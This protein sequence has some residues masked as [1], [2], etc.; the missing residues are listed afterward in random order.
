MTAHTSN[1]RFSSVLAASALASAG[2]HALVFFGLSRVD[3]SPVQPTRTAESRL[4]AL[5]WSEPALVPPIDPVPEPVPAPEPEPEPEPEPQPQPAPEPPPPPEGRLGIAESEQDT[6]NWLGVADP[7]EHRAMQFETE[8]PSWS[9][10]PGIPLPPGN[11][12]T[13]GAPTPAMPAA[14]EPAQ[15]A[16]KGDPRSEPSTQSPTAS[17]REEGPEDAKLDKEAREQTTGPSE[18]PMPLPAAA[19]STRGVPDAADN[20]HASDII[21]PTRLAPSQASEGAAEPAPD[22]SSEPSLDVAN[23]AKPE[24]ADDSDTPIAE[25]A[26]EASKGDADATIEGEGVIKTGEPLE[27]AEPVKLSSQEMAPL[28]EQAAL[29]APLPFTPPMAMKVSDAMREALRVATRQGVTDARTESDEAVAARASQA[30]QEPLASGGQA[31]APVP[32][33][34]RPAEISEADSSPT[35]RIPAI[36]VKLGRPAAGQGLEVITVRPRF[37]VTTTLT[38]DPQRS[39]IDVVFGRDGTVLK[40]AFVEGKTTGY[41]EVDGPLLDAVYRWRAKGKALLD[42][43]PGRDPSKGLLVTFHIE[44]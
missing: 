41:K 23:A 27:D 36:D 37:S 3:A 19:E 35:S 14:D 29:L 1:P 4:D 20:P 22:A 15:H 7:T 13:Q 11:A 21:E 32:P 10:Q 28:A 34:A 33:G 16:M 44:L 31:G 24:V 6:P 17:Q 9:P 43:P 40:A 8:Q 38:T 5:A 18:G 42:L 25:Q 39:S 26:R 2:L 12:S 30:A